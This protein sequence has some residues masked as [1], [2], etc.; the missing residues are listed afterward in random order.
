MAN[1]T[2]KLKNLGNLTYQ[3]EIDTQ[4]FEVLD[5]FGLGWVRESGLSHQS[6]GWVACLGAGFDYELSDVASASDEEDFG[7]G[8]CHWIGKGE[9]EELES[10]SERERYE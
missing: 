8:C 10:E 6:V 2:G 9:W 4:S 7:F 3:D 5:D 1:Q